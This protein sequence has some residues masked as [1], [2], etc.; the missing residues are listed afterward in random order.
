[1]V[2]AGKTLYRLKIE[3]NQETDERKLTIA[4]TL[5]VQ[6]KIDCMDCLPVSGGELIA[7]GCQKESISLYKFSASSKK[8]T[9]LASDRHSRLTCAV[10]IINESFIIGGDKFGNIFGLEKKGTR[11][12]NSLD[13][14]FSY[15][16]HDPIVKLFSGDF[17]H[18]FKMEK[19][20]EHLL[21]D[22]DA[23]KDSDL[24]SL[25]S[26][27]LT[28]SSGEF[29][30]YAHCLTGAIYELKSISVT[31]YQKLFGLEEILRKH[32]NL[33]RSAHDSVIESRVL[34]EFLS[35]ELSDQSKIVSEFNQRYSRKVTTSSV[36]AC[37]ESLTV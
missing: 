34:Q 10:K 3:K 30:I 27:H 1:L 22:C 9:F 16:M 2:A 6:W 37:I 23:E 18:Y 25:E 8:L 13:C 26:C 5:A 32:L 36:T 20:A 12:E 21:L 14:C 4:E 31:L 28:E 29:S 15:K 19:P 7:I 35:L 24:I 17:S 33:V 11:L